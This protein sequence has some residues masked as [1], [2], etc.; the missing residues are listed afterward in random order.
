MLSQLIAAVHPLLWLFESFPIL[1]VA[2]GMATH[3]M[4]YRLLVK[5][6]PFIE[7]T[8][9]NFLGSTGERPPGQHVTVP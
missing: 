9:V 2:F 3:G 4:Y 8:S 6:F 7:L 5:E 1:P